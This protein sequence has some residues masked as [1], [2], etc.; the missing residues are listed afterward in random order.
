MNVKCSVMENIALA[1]S[2]GGYRA[3]AYSLGCLSYLNKILYKGQPLLLNVTYISSTSGGSIANLLY[4]SY[5]FQGKSFDDFFAYLNE[6]LEGDAL[7]ND[8]LKKLTDADQWKNRKDKN[9]NIINAFS[10]VYDELLD[11]KDF[12]LFS[13]RS[14]NPHLEEICVNATEF[15]N[16]L[17]FRFQSQHPEGK[18]SRGKIGNRYINFKQD[19]IAHALKIKLSDILA[20]SS[21]FPSG[22][23]P[24]IFPDDFA[25]ENVSKEA[26]VN[27][28]SI[29]ENKYTLDT[30]NNSDFLKNATFEEAKQ[31]GIMDGGIADNQ[32]IDA[33]IRAD[34]R[35]KDNRVPTFDLFISCDVASYLMDGYT[36][37]VRKQKWYDVLTINHV[38]MVSFLLGCYLPLLFLLQPQE[39][40]PWQY[41]T[42]TL[43]G[44]FTLLWLVLIA[45]KLLNTATKKT[46]TDSW[47]LVFGKHKN[48][49][50][51]LSFGTLKYMLMSRAKS[52]FIL[53]ND[54]YLKQI[55]RMYYDK[56]FNSDRYKDRV[57]QNTIYDLSKV[58]FNGIDISTDP[59]HPTNSLINVA[60]KARKMGTTLWFDKNH[61]ADKVKEAI[62]ATGQFTTCYN[63][64]THINK[65]DAAALSQEM[66]DLKAALES[67]WNS[68]CEDPTFMIK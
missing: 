48:K 14:K 11:H 5:V 10:L 62:I 46:K 9:K 28:I 21:C 68:F 50:F 15:T 56:I 8:A 47:S 44:V 43:S 22:F 33:F 24:L 52:V 34:D 1:F 16:G 17:P 58:N 45:K 36:L 18:F 57:I 31:F 25:N 41:I 39:W 32:A 12:S 40:K 55:R 54:I 49:F 23:E 59:L 20:S 19:G 13:D 7:L 53:A 35:R 27:S 51:S 42:G 67:D 65:K 61:Q 38:V 60:E 3:A 26:L 64:L 29:S 30:Y 2:G 63:L 37:P 66:K 6:K 4:S